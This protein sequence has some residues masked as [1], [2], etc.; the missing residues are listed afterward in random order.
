MTKDWTGNGNSIYMSLG[1][2]NHSN[3]DRE[4]NDFYATHPESVQMFLDRIS[5]D[6][7]IKLPNNIYE[8]ACGEG[9]ISKK[10]IE[11]KYNVF[12]TDLI[13][14]GFGNLHNIDFINNDLKDID[15]KY[16]DCIITNPPYKYALDFVKKA[17]S[18]TN[19][20]TIM[21]LKIQFLEG[22]QRYNYYKNY[23]PKFIYIHSSRVGCGKNGGNEFNNSGAVCYSWFIWEKNYKGDP[24]IRF[25]E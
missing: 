18:I 3:S 25:I 6:D 14:R 16:F 4:D 23:P 7:D 20:Y 11:N 17:N 12:S 5:K 22:K 10:L 21:F 19:K 2:S 15:K 1:A 9:H 8:C 13:D 24:I